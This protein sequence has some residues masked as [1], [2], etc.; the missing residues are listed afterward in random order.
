MNHPEGH[1]LL[2]ELMDAEGEY[3]YSYGGLWPVFVRYV[4][5]HDDRFQSIK[6]EGQFRE[7][8]APVET[9]D[10]A[11]SYALALKNLSAYY[12]LELNPEYEYSVDELEDTHVKSTPDGYLVHLFSYQMF[13][14]GPHYTK[15]V[16]LL[17]TDRGTIE[18]VA[19]EPVY[20]DPS[21]DDLCVD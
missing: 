8:F 3:L 15:A 4:V 11:L 7:F 9:P 20:R 10:E 1:E 2:D 16:D 14:C 18:E 12:G 6:S 13:G 21:E 17:V 5:F 19:R